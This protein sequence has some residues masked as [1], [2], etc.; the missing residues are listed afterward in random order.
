MLAKSVYVKGGARG[1]AKDPEK[2][3]KIKTKSMIGGEQGEET[4]FEMLDELS[5]LVED[6][7]SFCGPNS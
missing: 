1:V 5:S 7:I 2:I 4:V 6:L 3:S